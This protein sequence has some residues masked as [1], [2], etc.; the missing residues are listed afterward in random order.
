MS[1]ENETL[2]DDITDDTGSSTDNQD[3]RTGEQT[4]GLTE[5]LS[6]DKSEP[7][8]ADIPEG[9]DAEIFD[10]ETRTLK[11]AAVV[12]RLKSLNTQLDNA[13]KQANDM[14]RKLSKG[15]SAPEKIEEYAASYKPEE[16][17]EFLNTDESDGAKHAKDVLGVLDDFAF[18]HGLS[19]ETAKDLKNLYLQYASDVQIIDGRSAE[20]KEAAK[21][22][23]VASQK[24]LLGDNADTIIKENV[25]F[26]KEYGV[27][28]EAERK[29][30][31]KAM[32]Q[33]AEWNTIGYKIR[34]LFGQSSSADIP[35]RGGVIVSG[36][37]DDK[38]LAKEYYANTTS[39]ARRME[40]LQQRIDNGR[41]GGLPMPE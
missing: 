9:L 13:K 37:A 35:V 6:S 7:Q 8:N 21:A 23:F 27:F 26:F 41:S 40:I 4:G 24:K 39:D 19:L 28:N 12:E 32:D 31:L 5:N 16:K 15:V 1:D 36:L 18:N 38:T 34:K 11:E 3:N 29:A 17:F 30:L 14:R 20:E 22:E 25:K 10:A 33:S 2:T